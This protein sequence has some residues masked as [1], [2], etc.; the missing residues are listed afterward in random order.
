[1]AVATAA[2]LVLGG[3][4]GGDTTDEPA[5]SA[6]SASSSATA[7]AE[8]SPGVEVTAPGSELSFGDSAVV[9]HQ[10][11]GQQTLL[12]LTVKSAKRGT[13]KDFAG[14]NM[15]DPY[16]RKANYYYVQVAAENVGEGK[17]GGVDVPLWGISGDN[18]LLPPVKFTSSFK[19][20]PTEP[21][22][23]RFG[24]GKK[25]SSCLVF[26]SPDK[27]TLEGVSYR[28]VESFDPIEWRGQVKPP[29]EKASKSK[30]KSKKRGGNGG[31]GGGGGGG[32]KN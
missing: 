11:R 29:T 25:H 9:D 2:G 14:F 8:S 21:L 6:S 20:C 5:A 24:P 26:L 1:V 3:C 17:L 12:E 27:G 30:K 22:P 32:N 4:A 23:K 18:T 7:T 28:P 16:Q 10:V 13:L 19:K 31:G 15:S